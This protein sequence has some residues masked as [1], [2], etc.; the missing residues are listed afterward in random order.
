LRGALGVQSTPG[1]GTTITVT[2]PL[3]VAILPAMMVRVAEEVYAVPL[4][5][6]IEIVRPIVAQPESIMGERVMRLRGSALPLLDADALFDAPRGSGEGD[7]TV[8]VLCAGA[9]RVGLRVTEVIG[10]QEVVVKPLDGL[11][12]SGPFSGATVRN[13]GGVSLVLDVAG[14]IRASV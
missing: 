6:I 7:R 9:R 8:L 11:R 3:T 4:S 12:K 1:G 10:K 5:G 14:L 2:I 13:D